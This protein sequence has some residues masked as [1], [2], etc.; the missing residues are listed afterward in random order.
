MDIVKGHEMTEQIVSYKKHRAR[1][2]HNENTVTTSY[3]DNS[4]DAVLNVLNACMCG[5]PDEFRRA[6]FVEKN[7]HL[8]EVEEVG[9]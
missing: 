4:H 5:E 3:A 2:W 6:R 9:E 7:F 8:V 1:Y